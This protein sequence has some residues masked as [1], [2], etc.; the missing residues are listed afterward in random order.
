HRR[1]HHRRLAPRRDGQ[2]GR[3]VPLAGLSRRLRVPPPDRHPDPEAAGS[4]RREDRRESVRREHDHMAGAARRK[5]GV[6][7]RKRPPAYFRLPPSAFRLFALAAVVLLV[8]AAIALPQVL[9]AYWTTN[10]ILAST[11]AIATLAPTAV[12][13]FPGEIS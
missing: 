7:S 6:G 10:L 13:G 4:A 5:S 11:Y 9:N 12:L 8:L 3:R 2:P 1:R